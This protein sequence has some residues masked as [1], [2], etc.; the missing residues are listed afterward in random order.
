[1]TADPLFDLSG[2]VAVVTG[3]SGGI[4]RMIAQ[5][6]LERGVRTYLVG[7]RAETVEGARHDLQATGDARAVAADVGTT[8]GRATLLAM[9]AEEPALHILVNNAGALTTS[10][11]DE[12]SEEDWDAEYAI[13]AKAPFFVAQ[14]LIGLMRAA[15]TD[16]RPATIINIGSA[17]GTRIRPSPNYAYQSSKAAIHHLTR[18]M[19]RHLGPEN[20]T[21]NAIAPGFFPSG[22]MP[23]R[24]SDTPDPKIE[25]A[26]VQVP[27][28][29]FGTPQD[30]GG[31]AV[32]LASRAAA[33]ITGVVLPVDGGL[34]L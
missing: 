28:R 3:A 29:R 6:L 31:A 33:Y 10:P 19:A 4:G 14:T 27:R 20:I 5:A 7:R 8:E 22:M 25:A 34:T 18:G 9:L 32:F 16:D 12:V 26:L 30:A 23:L 1:M 17:G 2:R 24:A 21:V 11:F 13:N 15:A